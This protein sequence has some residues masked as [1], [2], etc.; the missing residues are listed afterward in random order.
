M[1]LLQLSNISQLGQ[2]GK[3][4]KIWAVFVNY[5]LIKDIPL[6]DIKDGS[7]IP[8]K[9]AMW[10]TNRDTLL[11]RYLSR[12]KLPTL[13]ETAIKNNLSLSEGLQLRVANDKNK[14]EIKRTENVELC[15][16]VRGKD[17]L[18]M[19]KLAGL[20]SIHSFPKCALKKQPEHR[21]IYTR[22][23]R[24]KLPLSV[25]YPPHIILDE[26]R[27]FAVYSNDFVIVPPRQIGISA[28]SKSQEISLKA[29]TIYLKSNIAYYL[30]FWMAVNIGIERD[31]FNLDA[32]KKLPVPLC[33]LTEGELAEWAELYDDIVETEKKERRA[34]EKND[35]RTLWDKQRD[36]LAQSDSSLPK[37]D[38]LEA[39]E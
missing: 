37:L 8:W 22:K 2:Q 16:E 25:C 20:F 24:K 23:G 27:R 18:L 10:G 1:L 30:Q 11:F 14:K 19:N 38:D 17:I 5:S 39:N 32:L 13:N 36:A 21:N 9:I 4:N 26:S 3:S 15:N 33:S 7:S 12:R 34:K 28:K 31:V 35:K 6:K 29:L